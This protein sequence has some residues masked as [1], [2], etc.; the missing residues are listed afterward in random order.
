MCSPALPLSLHNKFV[1]DVLKNKRRVPLCSG[2]FN[3]IKSIF[4]RWTSY[5]EQNVCSFVCDQVFSCSVGGKWTQL[6]CPEQQA[7]VVTWSSSVVPKRP[8]WILQQ[9]SQSVMCSHTRMQMRGSALL[10]NTGRYTWERT[11]DRVTRGE[12]HTSKTSFFF[13]LL[14]TQLHRKTRVLTYTHLPDFTLEAA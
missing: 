6:S 5:K 10:K 7:L 14:L 1:I 11:P 3:S 8:G 2:G 9:G 13:S 12:I 4:R